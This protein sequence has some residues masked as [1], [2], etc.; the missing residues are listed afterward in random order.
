MVKLFRICLPARTLVLAAAEALLPMVLPL[1]A[2][3]TSGQTW[4][5]LRYENGFPR[6]G[7]VAAIF[8]LCMYYH[9]LYDSLVLRSLRQALMRLPEVLG[10]AYLLLAGLY[11]VAPGFRLRLATALVGMALAGLGVAL[12]RKVYLAIAHSPRLA[13]RFVLVGE[14]RLAQALAAEIHRRPEMGIR[15]AGQV[16]G[17]A[18]D[19]LANH[20]RVLAIAVARQCAAGVI[21]AGEHN[22]R[23]SPSQLRAI[24]RLGIE[25]LDGAE[26]YE[27]LTGKVWLDSLDPSQLPAMP[28]AA[29]APL[30]LLGKRLASIALSLVAL[31]VTAPLMALVAAAILLDSPGPMIFRQW[32]VGQNGRLFIL[33]KFRSM[34]S[35][36]A[37]AF[38]PAQE[39]DARFTR[40]GRLL[41]RTRLD[42]LPQLWNILRG[43]MSFVGPRP[44][45]WEEERHWARE[46]P[47][48]TERWR[49]KPGATGWAQ[50]HRGYCATREDNVEKLAYDLF[51]AKHLS[52][53]MDLLILFQTTKTLLR[54]RGAR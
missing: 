12:A 26:Y 19:P 24:E 51:Y 21:L 45:A 41:R 1:A 40:M 52:L 9:D 25:A 37:G 35:E 18:G 30:L 32:R 38:Q 13:E 31:A 6:V 3:A 54:G 16:S 39:N 53:G 23:R 5:W 29:A 28:A 33:Y 42:E 36:A 50:I 14:G 7:S 20:A 15:L 27:I 49:V 17:A 10:T 46:I 4:L 8:L 44:F 34:R 48:Y 11:L 43:D 22:A 47:F 2:V